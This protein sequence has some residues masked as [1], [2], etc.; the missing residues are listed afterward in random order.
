MYNKNTKKSGIIVKTEFF[1]E[2][3][4]PQELD[5]SAKMM[6]E[7]YPFLKELYHPKPA[8]LI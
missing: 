3:T 4:K 8:F 2:P 7:I 5:R 6:N 1:G